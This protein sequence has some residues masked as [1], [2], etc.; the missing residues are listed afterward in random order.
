MKRDRLVRPGHRKPPASLRPSHAGASFPLSDYIIP[1]SD[2]MGRSSTLPVAV[3]PSMLRLL[4]M[5]VQGQNLPFETNQDAARWALFHGLE[6]LTVL[7]KDADVKGA[8]QAVKLMVMAAAAQKS[9]LYFEKQLDAIFSTVE[10]LEKGG[11]E[12]KAVELADKVWRG[13]DRIDDPYWSKVYREKAKKV[14]D[15]MKRKN[16]GS[17]R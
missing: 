1:P 9:N 3:P 17:G 2:G 10:G 11:H 7:S 16:G 12:V 4:A 15:V 13:A 5:I 6:R 8:F 14:L